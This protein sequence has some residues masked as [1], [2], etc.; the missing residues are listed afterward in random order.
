MIRIRDATAADAD[1]IREIFLACY[2]RDYPWQDVYDNQSLTKTIY[3][4]DTLL[5]VA[6]DDETSQVLGTASV[7]LEIGAYSDLVGE[8]GRLAVHPDARRRGIG[9]LLMGERL[10]RVADRLHVGLAEARVTHPFSLRIAESEGF[11]PVGFLP[12][13]MQVG[14]RESLLLLARY[15]DHAL[16]LRGSC[17]RVI[18]EVY[19]LAHLSLENCGLAPDVIVDDESPPYPAY[20]VIDGIDIQDLSTEGYAG[21]L[22]IERGRV[23][24]REIFGP[25]RLH[26]GFFKLQA[27]NSRYLIARDQGRILGAIGF[28]L[29][30]TEHVVRIFE[31]IAL[32]DHIIGFLLSDLERRCR[33]EW[34][35]CYVEVDVSAHAPRM[36]R[37]LLE[38]GFLPAAYVPALVFYDVERLDVVKM[39]RLLTPMDLGQLMLSPT[40][41]AVADIV[42]RNFLGRDVLPKIAKAIGELELFS[43]LSSEQVTRLATACTVATFQPDETVFAEGAP[44]CALH[45]ILQGQV[46]IGMGVH[47]IPVGTVHRGECLGEMSVLTGAPHSATAQAVTVVETA[48]LTQAE[49]TRVVRLRPDIG[50]VAYRNLAAGIGRKL[51]R[52]D[53]SILWTESD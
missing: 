46:S 22:R 19:P 28:T 35:V 14:R 51:R 4:D 44:G 2:G 41:Q 47:R 43:G 32:D 12:L 49:F 34:G 11:A 20:P 1:S 24:H 33:E 53:Q 10:R 18:P 25:L 21:L 16:P 9:K 40:A 17:P 30:E 50:V 52:L 15:F 23:R 38:L 26:Y 5:L 42:L 31:L 13:K 27:R 39:V 3:S 6:E 29:D 37:T 36:Q 7:L 45:I 8:F 48:M